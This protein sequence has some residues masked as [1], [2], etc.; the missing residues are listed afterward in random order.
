MLSAWTSVTLVHCVLTA[1][2]Y[3]WMIS[4]DLLEGNAAGFLLSESCAEIPVVLPLSG[5]SNRDDV[6]KIYNFFPVCSDFLEMAQDR[7]VITV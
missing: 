1:V 4:L 2:T 3:Q 6:W 5:K 7:K